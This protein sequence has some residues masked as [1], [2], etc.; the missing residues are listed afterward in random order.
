MAAFVWHC[1]MV[2]GLPYLLILLHFKQV[3]VIIPYLQDDF[4]EMNYN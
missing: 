2:T 4:L 1:T 3:K